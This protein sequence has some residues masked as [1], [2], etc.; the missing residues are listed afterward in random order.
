MTWLLIVAIVIVISVVITVVRPLWGT[1]AATACA[2]AI[3]LKLGTLISTPRWPT[4][5][6]VVMILILVALSHI[7]MKRKWQAWQEAHPLLRLLREIEAHQRDLEQAAAALQELTG[8]PST[9]TEDS[10]E[11]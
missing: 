7:T 5:L 8:E 10:Q 2:A 9:P 1:W 4:I 6:E 11:E 3:G